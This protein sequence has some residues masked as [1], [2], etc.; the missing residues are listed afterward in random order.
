LKVRHYVFINCNRFQLKNS[1]ETAPVLAE[2]KITKPTSKLTRRISSAKFEHERFQIAV[3]EGA[4][5]FP[6]D[7]IRH[8]TIQVKPKITSNGVKYDYYL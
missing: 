2:G 7:L 6:S 4:I 1:P 8:L 3:P 5:F